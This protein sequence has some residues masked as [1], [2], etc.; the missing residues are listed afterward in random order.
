LKAASVAH[1]CLHRPPRPCLAS[2]DSSMPPNEASAAQG[3]LAKRQRLPSSRLTGHDLSVGQR[4]AK[5]VQPPQQTAQ[6]ASAAPGAAAPAGVAGAA[7]QSLPT[8]TMSGDRATSTE[9]ATARASPLQS[10][11]SMQWPSGQQPGRSPPKSLPSLPKPVKALHPAVQSK[12]P[13]RLKP[14]WRTQ[15]QVE[16][17][18][19][20][21]SMEQLGQWSGF[22]TNAV[23]S[24]FKI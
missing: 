11:G 18:N 6:A 24:P 5:P 10:I 15:E 16:H 13:G 4:G 8:A 7:A 17:I 20:K 3:P 22:K 12:G 23:R 21:S 14:V 9:A 19:K 2:I 1:A